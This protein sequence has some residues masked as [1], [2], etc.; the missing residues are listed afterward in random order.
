MPLRSGD[1]QFQRLHLRVLGAGSVALA[2]L[3]AAEQV[4]LDRSRWTAARILAEKNVGYNRSR[5]Q[6]GK[7]PFDAMEFALRAWKYLGAMREKIN[8]AIEENDLDWFIS[9]G[10]TLEK[11]KRHRSDQVLNGD[12]L[13]FFLVTHWTD[14]KIPLCRLSKGVLAEICRHCAPR[15]VEPTTGVVE[16][17]VHR[18]GLKRARSGV[19][20]HCGSLKDGRLLIVGASAHEVRRAGATLIV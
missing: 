16:V 20:G 5:G 4:R 1:L 14:S 18:L 10:K 19:I 15:S 13:G 6:T 11:L 3:S 2:D 8:H 17:A 12:P 9:F 7:K